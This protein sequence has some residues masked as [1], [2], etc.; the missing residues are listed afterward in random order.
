MARKSRETKRQT[1]L[2]FNPLS[3]SDP[4]RAAQ[5]EAVRARAAAVTLSVSPSPRKSSRIKSTALPTPRKSSQ[6]ELLLSSSPARAKAMPT[7]MSSS[8]VTQTPTRKKKGRGPSAIANYDDWGNDS[9]DSDTY[10]ITKDISRKGAS[11]GTSDDDDVVV[12]PRKRV[13]QIQEVLSDSESGS[14]LP[15]AKRSKT[16]EEKAQS[17]S[18]SD[19][20]VVNY[21]Q[22][23]R[24]S[25]RSDSGSDIPVTIRT[26]SSQRQQQQQFNASD[27]DLPVST[28]T[29]ALRRR[30][31]QASSPI[32]AP[33]S[34][35]ATDSDDKGSAAND[36][37]ETLLKSR[38]RIGKRRTEMPSRKPL[39][40]QDQDDLDED[41]E[42]LKS[43]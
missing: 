9:S 22:N 36:D 33:S 42:F 35:T 39:K 16:T 29:R 24:T 23:P 6:N 25:R 5:P 20:V 3:A 15:I 19:V 32:S 21:S 26:R 40:P 43:K 18:D 8:S 4:A 37:E 13:R 14:D 27:S 31:A 38:R 30:T 41:L 2:V 34:R 17:G 28:Q 11:L 7:F 10:S 12:N 1:T